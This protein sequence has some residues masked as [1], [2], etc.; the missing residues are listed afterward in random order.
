MDKKLIGFLILFI[1]SIT[2]L[3]LLI[4]A[5][6]LNQDVLEDGE[7][8]DEFIFDDSISPYTNQGLTVEIKRI[9]NR[10]LMEKMLKKGF[11]WRNKP[12][13]YWTCVV[14]GKEHNLS[15]IEAAGGVKGSGAFNDWDTF[16]EETKANFYVE[17]EQSTSNITISI[18]EINKKGLLGK[19]TQHKE[20]ERIELTF[21]YRTGRWMGSDNFKDDDGYGHYKGDEY[22]LWFN[23]KHATDFDH[24]MIPHWTENNIIGTDPTID[25][26]LND[27]DN[28]GIP[29]SWEWKWG[30]DPYTWDDHFNLDPDIDGIENIEEYMMEKWLADPFQPD[31]FIEIDGMEKGKIFDWNHISYEESHQMIYERFARH[32]INVYIDYGWPD[33]PINGGGELLPFIDVLDDTVGHHHNRFYRHNF[34]DDRKNIFRYCTVVNNAGFIVAG[35]Y[36][37]YD[38]IVV[39][40]SL[41]KTLIKRFGFTPRYQ[42]VLIA[43]S[44]LHEMGHSMGLMSTNFYGVDILSNSQDSRWPTELS[45]EE[46]NNYCKEY[47]SIMN[48]DYIFGPL[49]K[50]KILFDYSDGSNSEI[51]DQNDWIHFYLP[52]FQF[53]ATSIEEAQ[54]TIDKSMEDI[55]DI[56][57]NPG[58]MIDGWQYYENLTN[59][60]VDELDDLT[61]ITNTNCTY[62]IYL[63]NIS[64][65]SHEFSNRTVRI[66]AKPYVEPV[67]SRWSL[68]AEGFMNSD[69][70]IIFYSGG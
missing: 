31:I 43:K 45:E 23:I 52:A 53:D 64:D 7:E 49:P 1:V 36:N 68:I 22:E 62:K 14:D 32:G 41:Y 51:Y 50:Q 28:D 57:K 46:Y 3:F 18:I 59:E 2:V 38:H 35:D 34:D 58:I 8:I 47:Y 6:L 10:S 55:E 16:G 25:D 69:N 24:D 56:D 37:Y 60:Y 27:P 29:T 20:I 15:S 9:R 13:F 63:K 33:G 61:F 11:S 66:Y 44:I 12:T 4:F 48:Y 70:E 39:D 21:D 30:Y 19:K 17:E 54:P 5:F 40:S 65:Y 26:S 42:R 67:P